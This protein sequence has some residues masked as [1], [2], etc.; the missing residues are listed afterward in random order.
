MSRTTKPLED[1]FWAKVDRRG[2]TDC[3]PWLAAKF[4]GKQYGAF[5]VG[6]KQRR[7]HRVAYELEKGALQPDDV[8]CHSCDNPACCNP[9]HLWK[10]THAENH[11][12]REQKGRGRRLHGSENPGAVLKEDDV[13]EIRRRYAGGD[14]TQRQLAREYHVSQKAVSKIVRGVAWKNVTGSE[15]PTHHP[16]KPAASTLKTDTGMPRSAASG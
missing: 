16:S 14:C 1:R 13:R 4:A 15:H 7:A 3:W 6:E 9:A 12:D 10:G 5:R 2:A 8:V 11:A